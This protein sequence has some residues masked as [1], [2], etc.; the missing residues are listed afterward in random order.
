[1][2]LILHQNSKKANILAGNF[3]FECKQHM[4]SNGYHFAEP[5]IIDGKIKRI[6]IDADKSKK[7]E[8]YIGYNWINDQGQDSYVVIYGSFSTGEKFKFSS[9]G[10]GD[11]KPTAEQIAQRQRESERR[12]QEAERQL[13]ITQDEKAAK[14]LQIWQS[15][16]I[17]PPTEE[18]LAYCNKKGI[19]PIGA[20]FD[21]HKGVPSLIIPIY[22]IK[23]QLRSLQFIYQQEGKFH[24]RFVSGSELSGNFFV[25]TEQPLEECSTVYIAE[26]YATAVSIY[27]ALGRQAPVVFALGAS[28]LFSATKK[29]RE[30]YP[31]IKIIVCS[32]RDKSGTGQRVAAQ[33]A[34]AFSAEVVM[35][36]QEG[37]FNDV[38]VALGLAEVKRQITLEQKKEKKE[39]K[40]TEATNVFTL[41]PP[42]LKEYMQAMTKTTDA[43]SIML[44]SSTLS[45]LSGYLGNK[46]YI[47]KGVFFQDLYPNLWV[48]C[49]S[50]SGAFKTTALNAGSHI[51]RKNQ[52]AVKTDMRLAI[53]SARQRKVSDQEIKDIEADYLRHDILL[54]NRITM[55]GLLDHLDMSSSGVMYLSEFGAFLKNLSKN[56][57]S[58]TMGTLTDLY[59]V[60]MA[61]AIRTVSKGERLIRKPA[62]SICGVSTMDWLNESFKDSDVTGGFLMRFLLFTI[63]KATKLPPA[64]PLP[65]SME[66]QKAEDNFENYVKKIMTIL[67]HRGETRM[68]LAPDARKMY[69]QCYES[70]N[71]KSSSLGLSLFESFARRWSPTVLKIATIMQLLLDPESTVISQTAIASAYLIVEKA[72]ASTQ[73]MLL[74]D[75]LASKSQQDATKLF[76]YI[77]KK[78]KETGSPVKKRTILQSRCLKSPDNYAKEVEYYDEILEL[79]SQQGKITK[80]TDK[81]AK[82]NDMYFVSDAD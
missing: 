25:L 5:L 64:L 24:K 26:G 27:M 12:Q 28:N 19:A 43:D 70:I 31:L 33:V 32:D 51:A 45:M 46:V 8:W 76:N 57:N 74:G 60:P 59:D 29:I 55:E 81:G 58:D 48:L 69:I 2:D 34:Q 3:E 78:M 4:A 52:I 82:K 23:R 6:S 42:A 14:A 16:S 38:H 22:N 18:H 1:M 54:P 67:T 21:T 15:A 56:Y 66:F 61:H 77:L 53:A 63:P 20:R 72:M 17:K 50:E 47:P 36:E 30:Y 80:Q 35:P 75:L 68:N 41:L 7:D 71:K 65:E 62:I 44:L 73:D 13:T 9:W 39:Q 49:I 79:L 10:D 37:D 40:V 11:G